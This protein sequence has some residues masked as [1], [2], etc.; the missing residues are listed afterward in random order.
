MVHYILTVYSD[1]VGC[2]CRG[3]VM[4]KNKR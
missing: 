2:C 1:G 4:Q 3:K